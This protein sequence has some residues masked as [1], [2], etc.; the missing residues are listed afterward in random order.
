MLHYR[1]SLVSCLLAVISFGFAGIASAQPSIDLKGKVM[2]GD[3]GVGGAR[4]SLLVAK[5]SDTTDASG[6]FRILAEPASVSRPKVRSNPMPIAD[7]E[8]EIFDASGRLLLMSR[9]T[10]NL[11]TPPLRQ[12]ETNRAAPQVSLAKSAAL[13]DTL[14][15]T[16]SG[17]KARKVPVSSYR[18]D[19]D[20]LKLQPETQDFEIRKLTE[21]TLQCRET[22][23]PSLDLDL[24]CESDNDSLLASV[25][26]QSKPVSCGALSA[27]NYTV[28][29][30]WIK[31]SEGIQ[32]LSQVIYDG[33]GNHRND[34][35]TFAWK[36]KFF[37]FYHSSF[38]FGWRAC[39][40]PDCMQ[41]CQDK[42]CRTILYD[43]CHR[44][45]C[46]SPPALKV[47]CAKVKLDGTVPARLDPWAK[48]EGVANYPLL[49]CGG[50]PVCK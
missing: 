6:A 12:V 13:L 1:L 30:A 49:P 31:T 4:V 33:G 5:A 42:E 36:G 46:A 14:L 25:Y 16:R 18:M 2:A 39:A 7:P 50:D 48:Q 20:T 41:I 15:I 47:R 43:G 11:S 10:G 19:L 40:S 3:S 22:S 9:E 29:S 26:V 28:E 8:V 23:V 27:I 37:S 17:F 35:I 24:V 44:A 45:T 32:P 21:R 34:R 38:G